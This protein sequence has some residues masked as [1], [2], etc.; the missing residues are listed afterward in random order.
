MVQYFADIGGFDA[1]INLLK[2]SADVNDV[3]PEESK[4][5][6]VKKEKDASTIRISF[7]MIQDLCSPFTH[8]GN[9][10]TQ[11]FS[12]KYTKLVSKILEQ[13]MQGM[14][15]KDIKEV[16]KDEICGVLPRL[17]EFFRVGMTP[18]EGAE[19]VERSSLYIALRFLKSEN[20]EK[21]LKGLN[22]IR[23]MVDRVQQ[24]WRYERF[25]ARS[26]GNAYQ[27]KM[28]YE[29]RFNPSK[30][31]NVESMSQ[32]LL[33]NQVLEIILGGSAHIEIVKRAGMILKFVFK[34][35]EG[36]FDE[37]AVN[38]LW[39]AQ[40]GKFEDMVRAV[41]NLIEE[42]QQSFSLKVIDSFFSKI[43]DV[44][45]QQFDEKHLNFLR[46]FT[47][48]ALDKTYRDKLQQFQ[49]QVGAADGDAQFDAL[50]T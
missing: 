22:D 34:Y 23:Y 40:E 16:D 8:I 9:V 50:L 14:S 24:L 36:K 48:T 39:K 46:E 19:V 4:S 20:L 25:K 21:R 13:R 47:K 17:S 42:V 11:E 2:F 12:D 43:K 31:M 37:E 45:L 44:P 30:F 10:L 32:W 1:I 41:Y 49:A 38:L 26:G 15:E 5:E 3:Y 29:S 27:Y 18:S 33:E 6:S 28:Q 35:G 7:S